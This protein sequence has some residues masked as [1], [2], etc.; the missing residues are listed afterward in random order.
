MKKK[1]KNGFTIVELLI[2]I[3]I[4]G[5]LVAISIPYINARLERA[6]EAHDIAT[7]RAAASAAIDLYYAGVCDGKTADDAGLSWDTGGGAVSSNAYGAYDPAT[8]RFY[9]KR[10]LLPAS[11]KKYGRGTKMD[12][13]T[14]F[15]SGSE[16]GLA[17]LASEDYTNAVVMVS[18]YP[19]ANPAHVDVYW[20]NNDGKNK[21]KYVGGNTHTNIPDYCLRIVLN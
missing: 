21:N 3:G 7:M 1:W 17:Y 20:K 8:G 15:E 19:K 5:I 4:I 10:D 9:K 12:G 18:I 14:V 16:K 13:G 6:R 2:V 11:A